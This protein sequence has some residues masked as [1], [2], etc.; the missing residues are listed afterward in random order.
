MLVKAAVLGFAVA[1]TGTGQIIFDTDSGQFGDDGV[2]LTMMMRSPRRG[3]VKAVT[4]VSGNVWAQSGAGFMR[5]NLKLLGAPG[6]PVHVGAQRP[7][8]HNAAM[9]QQQGAVEFSGAF[10][11]PPERESKATAIEAMARIIESAPGE[12]T[13]LAIGPLTNVAIL[14]RLRPDLETRIASIVIMGGNVRVPGNATAAAEFNFWFDPEAAQ[15]VLRSAIPRKVLF[16]LDVCN[17][18]KL[19]KATFDQVVAV[20][21]PITELYRDDFGNRYPGFLKNPQAEGSLW[22][23]LAA[24]SLIDPKVVTRVE[25]MYLDVETTFGRRYG[26]VKELNRALAP[27]ATPVDVVFDMNFER[28]MEI[29][30]NALTAR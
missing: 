20:K 1:L 12:V 27:A 17:K 23:E 4:V 29:Y 10:A 7:L 24:A 16:A 21:T 5:R 22:D 9:S 14:L 6:V 25:S 3:G 28:C 19:T 11:T 18:I 30:R 15:A 8:I 13:I 2:A 26:A